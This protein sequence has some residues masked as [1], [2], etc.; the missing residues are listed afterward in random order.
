M[1]GAV[2]DDNDTVSPNAAGHYHV[3][4]QQI[5]SVALTVVQGFAPE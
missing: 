2:P 5:V 4:N 1:R 3:R